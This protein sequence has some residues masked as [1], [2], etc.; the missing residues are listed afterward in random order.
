MSPE[1]LMALA[2]IIMPL[3]HSPTH[4]YMGRKGM[5]KKTHHLYSAAV[6]ASVRPVGATKARPEKREGT[7]MWT[8]RELFQNIAIRGLTPSSRVPK[9]QKYGL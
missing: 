6:K 7:N 2:E 8:R 5:E 1:A 3:V 9:T 4:E